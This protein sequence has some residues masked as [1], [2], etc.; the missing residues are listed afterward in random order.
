MRPK[1]DI[2]NR[3][4][5]A[6]PVALLAMMVI[7]AIVTGGFYASSREAGTRTNADLESQAFYVAEY[8]LDEVLGTVRN[9]ALNAIDDVVE[10]GPVE[11]R[12]AGQTL[13]YYEVTVR[14]I[15]ARLFLVTSEGHARAGSEAAARRVGT[16]VR[17]V[18]A[19]M[20]VAAALVVRNALQMGGG[21]QI[22]GDDAGGPGCAAGSPVA[23]VVAYDSTGIDVPTKGRISG[24]PPVAQDARLDRTVLSRFG[25]LQLGDL[26]ASAT[27]TYEGGASESRM[28]PVVKRDSLGASICDTHVRSN[29]GDPTGIGPCGDE[30]PI[31][32][33]KGDLDLE[34]GTGQGILIVDGNLKASGSFAFYGVVIVLGELETS[35]T[36]NH[37]EGSV[38]VQGGGR[39]DAASTAPGSSLVEYSRC[40]VDRAFDGVLRARPLAKRSWIDFSASTRALVAANGKHATK[41]DQ[42][43]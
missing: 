31:I 33:A 20:P 15:G 22:R 8:G 30:F 1:M 35:G 21:S 23:G 9:D 39:L 29:W 4:G 43:G 32:H 37:L 34:R 28:G 2:E 26:I 18:H 7:G 12:S 14:S 5:F 38:M 13:G 10:H 11:V 40:R 3:H 16:V 17:T 6:L 24:E 25:G 42:R 27:R 41:K 36:G 19:Q